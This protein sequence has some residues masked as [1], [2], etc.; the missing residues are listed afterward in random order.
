MH[1]KPLCH[2]A[3]LPR[4]KSQRGHA[5]W[6]RRASPRD[7][8]P[9]ELGARDR[10]ESPIFQANWKAVCTLQRGK[11]DEVLLACC[12]PSLSCFCYLRSGFAEVDV[13]LVEVGT[14]AQSLVRCS[15]GIAEPQFLVRG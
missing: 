12:G 7:A 1:Q 14:V 10:G 6:Q 4:D 11:V 8:S 2:V 13:Y 15:R 9:W 3:L 5:G